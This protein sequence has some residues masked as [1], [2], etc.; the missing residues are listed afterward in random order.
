MTDFLF[1]LLLTLPA[2]VGQTYFVYRY[3]RY[4]TWYASTVGRALM[5][6]S[7]ALMLLVDVALVNEILPALTNSAPV[8]SFAEILEVAAYVAVSIAIW[9]QVSVLVQQQKKIK[10]PAAEKHEI[11]DPHDDII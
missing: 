7:A 8:L 10:N 2:A 3:H 9:H 11:P 1:A 6:K 4:S 5:V